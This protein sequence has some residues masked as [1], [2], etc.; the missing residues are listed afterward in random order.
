MSGEYKKYLRNVIPRMAI[1]PDLESILCA[2]PSSIDIQSWFSFLL[3][4]IFI[5]YKSFK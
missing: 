4:V 1:H 2:T 3:K 5:T